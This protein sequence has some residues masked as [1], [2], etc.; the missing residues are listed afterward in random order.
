MYCPNISLFFFKLRWGVCIIVVELFVGIFLRLNMKVVSSRRICI[1]FCQ[2]L[3][4]ITGP[5]PPSVY[6][7]AWYFFDNPLMPVQTMP[8]TPLRT[9]QSHSS[10]WQ[11]SL[12]LFLL[13]PLL[14]LILKENTFGSYFLPEYNPLGS[15]FNMG[16]SLLLVSFSRA[17]LGFSLQ[18]PHL[19]R[20]QLK[21]KFAWIGKTLQFPFPW[22]FDLLIL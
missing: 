12:L 18:P 9:D 5:R 14:L 15:K 4:A 20:S 16:Q 1:C 21:T 8:T 11:A 7:T 3:G 10:Q 22:V 19:V 6:F 2:V 17:G 13:F